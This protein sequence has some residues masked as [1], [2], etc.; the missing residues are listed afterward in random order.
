MF[1]SLFYFLSR[2]KFLSRQSVNWLSLIQFLKISPVS[3]TFA[4]NT[5][6]RNQSYILSEEN[7]FWADNEMSDNME[8]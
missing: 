4:Q 8:C 2:Y 7:V 3:A 1:A 6:R 5:L